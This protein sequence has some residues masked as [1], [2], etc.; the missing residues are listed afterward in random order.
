MFYVVYWRCIVLKSNFK[1]I[2]ILL[3]SLAVV[4]TICESATA[5][6]RVNERDSIPRGQ[7]S[8]FLEFQRQNNQNLRQIRIMPDC[9]FGEGLG[10][11]KT[12]TVVEQI[13]NQSR[14]TNYQDILMRAAGGE[15]NYR[16]FAAF[17][18]NNS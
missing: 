1:S 18:D 7:E 16:K 3:S 15:D 12:G 13:I 5:Q 14:G 8:E 6:L 4:L 10:C 9:S 11:N 17:Y 2:A